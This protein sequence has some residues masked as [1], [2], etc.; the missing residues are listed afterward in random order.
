MLVAEFL[1]A[2]ANGGLE[3]AAAGAAAR[4]L[5]VAREKRRGEAGDFY[6]AFYSV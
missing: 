6:C 3:R 1:S 4:E 2:L 5:A